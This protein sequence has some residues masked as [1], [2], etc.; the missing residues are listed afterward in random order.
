MARKNKSG[1]RGNKVHAR[2][3]K[4]RKG[5]RGFTLRDMLMLHGFDF[6]KSRRK[7]K[8]RKIPLQLRRL[9]AQTLRDQRARRRR[10]NNR[11]IQRALR[12]H[13]RGTLHR[14]L[15]VPI[16]KKIPLAKLRRA[17]RAGGKLGQRAR[18]A[19]NLRGLSHKRKR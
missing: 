11:W 16:G 14:M 13:K 1:A 2:R 3:A 12:K 18:L 6:K 17:A 7:K 9:H 19:L 4:H 15:R 10:K 5:R 8:Q